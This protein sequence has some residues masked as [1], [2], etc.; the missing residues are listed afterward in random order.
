MQRA[1]CQQ[2]QRAKIDKVFLSSS[3]V[4]RSECVVVVILHIYMKCIVLEVP[5]C[6]FRIRANVASSNA[7]SNALSNGTTHPR[8]SSLTAVSEFCKKIVLLR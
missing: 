8:E 2:H 4:V 6:L 3:V 5:K 1:S 7:S